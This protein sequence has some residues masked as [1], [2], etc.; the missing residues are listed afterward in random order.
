MTTTSIYQSNDDHPMLVTKYRDSNGVVTKI[1]IT[2]IKDD[3]VA[4]S[5]PSA[6]IEQ[7][8]DNNE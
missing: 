4:E 6:D 2:K 3:R 5:A 8:G 7:E 1:T